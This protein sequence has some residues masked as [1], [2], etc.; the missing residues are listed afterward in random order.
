MTKGF[1][2]TVHM[3]KEMKFTYKNQSVI[4]KFLVEFLNMGME[5]QDSTV[6]GYVYYEF[7]FI[8]M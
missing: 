1:K 4:K 3:I 2:A 7:T 8:H 5:L 6:L